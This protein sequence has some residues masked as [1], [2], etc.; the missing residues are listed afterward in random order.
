M[1][2]VNFFSRIF[3]SG[4]TMSARIKFDE[5]VEKYACVSSEEIEKLIKNI[6]DEE[7]KLYPS[8]NN[9]TFNF[10]SHYFQN[11]AFIEDDGTVWDKDNHKVFICGPYFKIK[12]NQKASYL[13]VDW[14]ITGLDGCQKK[15]KEIVYKIETI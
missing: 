4:A 5:L 14:R 9:D 2:A 12:G 13:A 7:I 8:L 10:E 15:V 11:K 6:S 1:K 3:C